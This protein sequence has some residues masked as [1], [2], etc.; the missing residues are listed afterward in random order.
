MS[1]H[2]KAVVVLFVCLQFHHQK[3]GKRDV[4]VGDD[5]IR[6]LGAVLAL[7]FAG[8]PG[9]SGMSPS[10][11]FSMFS[12][13]GRYWMYKLPSCATSAKRLTCGAPSV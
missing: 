10:R 6:N 2:S 12:L 4:T 3:V 13:C 8:V 11:I 7:C 1:I 5:C 9:R